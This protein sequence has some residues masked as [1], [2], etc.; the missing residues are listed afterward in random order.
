M[1]VDV[2]ARRQDHRSYHSRRARTGVITDLVRGRPHPAGPAPNRRS[3]DG[4]APLGR[5]RPAAPPGV[6]QRRRPGVTGRLAAP[7][8]SAL[9]LRTRCMVKSTSW[10]STSPAT[11]DMTMKSRVGAPSPTRTASPSRTDLWP[12]AQS[13]RS[14]RPPP[15]G[16][17]AGWAELPDPV[18]T[19]A[20]VPDAL[21]RPFPAGPLLLGATR[22]AVVLLLP[23]QGGHRMF[24]LRST[25]GRG[26]GWQVRGPGGPESGTVRPR[27][28]VRPCGAGARFV[29][30]GFQGRAG[31]IIGSVRGR[32]HSAGRVP[33]W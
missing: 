18:V 5:A 1:I 33:N 20:A 8:R 27:R 3:P 23:A 13:A 14:P 17:G 29:G 4:G 26:G 31:V 22:P 2:T 16:D 15:F 24:A 19:W 25:S 30:G 32:P 21:A 9:V 28:R 10:G 7:A 6:G 11:P 12:P